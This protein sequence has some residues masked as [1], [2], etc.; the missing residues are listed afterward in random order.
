M[1]SVA[2]FLGSQL[3]VCVLCLR[4]INIDLLMLIMLWL[5][6]SIEVILNHL[7]AIPISTLPYLGK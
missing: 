4:L 1:L 7:L 5:G 6:A 2:Y 3:I